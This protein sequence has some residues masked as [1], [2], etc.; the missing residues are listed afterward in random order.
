MT[1]LPAPPKLNWKRQSKLYQQLFARLWRYRG[2]TLGADELR[3]IGHACASILGP[4]VPEIHVQDTVVQYAGSRLN[5]SVVDQ[6]ARQ[7]SFRL[8][9][10]ITSPL[11]RTTKIA[12]EG[13]HLIEIYR[14]DPQDKFGKM[15]LTAKFYVL[16]G[17]LAGQYLTPWFNENLLSY[18]AYQAL[19]FSRRRPYEYE[20]HLLIGLRCWAYL[21]E[22]EEQTE[23]VAWED[24]ALTDKHNKPI[25][26]LR[27]RFGIDTGLMDELRAQQYSCPSGFDHYCHECQV[28]ANKCVASPLRDHLVGYALDLKPQ[29]SGG[30]QGDT[31]SPAQ[32][33]EGPSGEEVIA[34]G[35]SGA[36][37][38]RA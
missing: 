2:Q 36:D 23:I 33:A 28:T 12:G 26:K 17:Q 22:K 38:S 21:R 20:P 24:N 14:L 10:L 15:G 19:G 9:D 32:R 29:G 34:P 6:L 5:P 4:R 11:M 18:L 8:D 27:L 35:A 13:W 31:G 30:G 3:H 7:L 1:E 16:S 37:Q 25:L